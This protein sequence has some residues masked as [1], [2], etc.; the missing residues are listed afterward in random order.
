MRTTTRFLAA[1][2][3]LGFGSGY[4]EE[5][6]IFGAVRVQ[7]PKVESG[8]VDVAALQK[9]VKARASSFNNCYG[10]ELKEK[11]AL[12]GSLTLRCSIQTSGRFT[13]P[14]VRDDTMGSPSLVECLKH[15]P[16]GWSFKPAPAETAVVLIPLELKVIK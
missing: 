3:V 5:P 6:R 2:A 9:F 13:A 16:S 11:P 1:L 12:E 14:E 15:V 10:K 4:A 7:M 8:S